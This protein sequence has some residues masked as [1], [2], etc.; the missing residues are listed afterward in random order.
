[1]FV[2]LT[3]R[4][5]VW[6]TFRATRQ[7]SGLGAAIGSL[8]WVFPNAVFEVMRKRNGP[9]YWNEAEFTAHLREAGFTVLE[10]RRTFFDGVSLLAWARK[11]EA[12]AGTGA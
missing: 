8:L 1:V 12:A 7:R 3:R 10:M 11:D 5:P 4:L 9:H 6:P 2:N